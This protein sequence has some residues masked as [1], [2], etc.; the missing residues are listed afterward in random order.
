MKKFARTFAALLLVL[1][2][3]TIAAFAAVSPVADVGVADE[4]AAK[5]DKGQAVIVTAASLT[6]AQESAFRNADVKTLMGAA[7]AADEDY[8]H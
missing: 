7:A 3:G 5:N 1:A 2:M 6:Q 4:A 8:C